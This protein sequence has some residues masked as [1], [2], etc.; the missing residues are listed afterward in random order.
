MSRLSLAIV[1]PALAA[2]NNGNWHTARRWARMLGSRYRVR[3]A[4][5]W[6]D[7][8]EA[9]MIALHAR[10]SAAS[11][12]AW[13]ARH[14]GRPLVVV[15]TG[16]D[17]YRDIDFDA[18]AQRSLMLADALVVLNE[19]GAHRLPAALRAKAQVVLQSSPARA[20]LARTAHHLRALMVGHLRDEKDPRT[21]WRAAERLA[22]RRDIR[23]DHIGSALEPAL[24][25]QATALAAGRPQFR[26]LGGRPHD[27]VRRRVQRAHV[28]VNASRMEGGAQVVIEAIRSGTPVLASRIDGHLGLLGDDY[29]G[30]FA[31]SDDAALAA[32]LA[33]ARDDRDMLPRLAATL[34]AR[35][36]RFAPQ[37]ERA[38]LLA[39]VGR[40]LAR[41]PDASTP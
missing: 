12:A 28:L 38:A 6:D 22:A 27:E 19:L 1:T 7:G 24:G 18:A 5:A 13:H 21:Y 34:A 20:A 31:P 40:L 29:E 35:S 30:L 9:G 15:L 25:A 37:A 32:L 8:D 17:L 16:T 39:L 26:W 11:I 33:R 14:P 41:A 23:L 2:A 10:R 36:P 3:L 4:D